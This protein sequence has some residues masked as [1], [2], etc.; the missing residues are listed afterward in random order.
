M[1]NK[2]T[3]THTHTHTHITNK[4]ATTR[5]NYSPQRSRLAGQME[6]GQFLEQFTLQLMCVFHDI[7]TLCGAEARTFTATTHV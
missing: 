3:D 5:I 7:H 1:Y 6:F 2:L 4:Y